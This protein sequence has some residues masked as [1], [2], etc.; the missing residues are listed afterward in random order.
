MSMLEQWLAQAA[1]FTRKHVA[2][3]AS[4]WRWAT[5]ETVDP[6]TIRYDGTPAPALIPPTL[7]AAPVAVG[8]RVR[9]ITVRGQTVAIPVAPFDTGWEPVSLNPGF[10]HQGNDPLEVRHQGNRVDMRWGISNA[11]LSTATN[12]IIG[13]LPSGTWPTQSVYGLLI[14]HGP[15]VTGRV[16]IQING[17]IT[18]LPG[19]TM[20]N[21]F[22]FNGVYW[23]LD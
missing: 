13:T 2:D 19:T 23:F 5:V 6:V 4:L 7:L 12:A 15:E 17:S 18:V 1:A 21:Y 20:S 8:D 11:G 22:L 16:Y 10:A 3:N 14:G 9:T